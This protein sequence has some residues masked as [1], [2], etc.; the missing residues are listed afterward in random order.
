[1]KTLFVTL[2]AALMAGSLLMPDIAEAKRFGA[3]KS[4]GKQ[5]S[6]TPRKATPPSQASQ[7]PRLGSGRP[8]RAR[9]LRRAVPVVGSARWQVSPP[10]VCSRRCSSATA[11]KAFRSWTF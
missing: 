3:G 6:T 9:P 8:R 2:M 1:M 7:A 4:F 11:S 10:A 5:Y